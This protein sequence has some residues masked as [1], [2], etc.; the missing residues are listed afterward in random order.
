VGMVNGALNRGAKRS[1]GGGRSGSLV[2][3]TLLRNVPPDGMVFARHE[4]LGPVV[5]VSQIAAMEDARRYLDPSRQL[6]VS[7]F[8]RDTERAIHL[9]HSLDVP[10]VHVNGIPSWRDGLLSESRSPYRMGRH[11]IRDR[12]FAMT[13]HKDIVH[14]PQ[15]SAAPA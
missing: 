10:N 11:T 3:P 4:F 1:C 14:H 6:V 9:A 13:T 15:G 12:A 2:E 7:I 5:G 8:A